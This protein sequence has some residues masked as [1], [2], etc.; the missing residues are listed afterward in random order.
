MINF[1]KNITN[2]RLC[3]IKEELPRQS[4][5]IERG[6]RI[7]KRLN[8]DWKETEERERKKERKRER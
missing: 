3:Q 1:D 4:L 2:F 5:S 6:E 8:R 7:G